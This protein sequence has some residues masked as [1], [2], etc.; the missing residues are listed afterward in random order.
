MSHPRQLSVFFTVCLRTLPYFLSLVYL[1]IHVRD[2]NYA[3]AVPMKSISLYLNEMWVGLGLDNADTAYIFCINSPQ[4]R[5][6]RCYIHRSNFQF[7]NID[8][9][10]VYSIFSPMTTRSNQKKG[11]CFNHHTAVSY[12]AH[13]H[14]AHPRKPNN[15]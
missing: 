14:S 1:H 4:I 8:K 9:A 15:G 12:S 11:C 2:I 7:Y 3:H 10:T 5:H 13:P 6:V